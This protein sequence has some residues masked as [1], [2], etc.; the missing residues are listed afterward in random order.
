MTRDAVC[1]WTRDA[2]WLPLENI[3]SDGALKLSE[4]DGEDDSFKPDASNFSDAMILAGFPQGLTLSNSSIICV[5][6]MRP[7]GSAAS[8]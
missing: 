1:S 2:E 8:Q 3:A 5:R 7:C 4:G 6:G